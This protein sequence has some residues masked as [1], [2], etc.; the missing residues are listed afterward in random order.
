MGTISSPTEIDLVNFGGVLP[1]SST[2]NCLNICI[3]FRGDVFDLLLADTMTVARPS[4]P[5]ELP[6]FLDPPGVTSLDPSE[7]VPG[8]TLVVVRL[9]CKLG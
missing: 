2:S 7:L 9:R 5:D 4:R 3:F 1:V 8:A 6:P